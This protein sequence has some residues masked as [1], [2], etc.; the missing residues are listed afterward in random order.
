MIRFKQRDI[1]LISFPFTNLS[2]SK[3]RPALIISSDKYNASH[4]D[5]IIVA[6]TSQIPAT[7]SFDEFLIPKVDL[8][9]A[10]LPKVSIIKLGKIITLHQQL[11]RKKLGY[12]SQ[13]IFSEEVLPLLFDL[14]SV[15]S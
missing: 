15:T 3:Q 4:E 14:F 7:L 12:I 11:V 13:D 5:L 8:T 10:G 2:S 6:I 9:I 1:V